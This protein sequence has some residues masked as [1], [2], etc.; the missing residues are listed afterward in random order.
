MKLPQTKPT[1]VVIVIG[2]RGGGKTTLAK[3]LLRTQFAERN[4]IVLDV[5]KQY[6]EDGLVVDNSPDLKLAMQHQEPKIIFQPPMV[7]FD[8]LELVCGYIRTYKNYFLVLEEANRYQSSHKIGKYHSDALDRGRHWGAGLLE[9]TRRTALL[10]PLVLSQGT[11]FFI[12]KIFLPVDL[13]Y[14]AGFLPPTIMEQIRT[15]ELYES[16][17]YNSDTEE[18]RK[19]KLE[20]L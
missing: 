4:F 10:N 9:I 18:S 13:D 15:L 19:I 2:K 11:H 5:M 14:L 8:L 12:F 3:H 17:Y 16:L 6:G 1:D 20:P 7:S